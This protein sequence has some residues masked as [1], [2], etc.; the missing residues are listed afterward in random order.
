MG[1]LDFLFGRRIKLEAELRVVPSDPTESEKT[2]QQ[3]RIRLAEK[4]GGTPSDKDVHWS[5]YNKE[6][7]DHAKRQN[8][9]LYRNTRFSMAEQL[10]GENKLKAALDT[11]CEVSFLDAN[12][13]SNQNGFVSREF[14]AFRKDF[15]FQAP[16]VVSRI[17]T[18]AQELKFQREDLKSAYLAAAAK[19][20]SAVELPL[21]PEQA[22][23]QLEK[24]LGGYEEAAAESAAIDK[25]FTETKAKT[26]ELIPKE[27]IKESELHKL[28]S[29]AFSEDASE[30]SAY[31]IR[32]Y[33]EE[34]QRA[35]LVARKKEGRNWFVF[36]SSAA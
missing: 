24:D 11:F 12:G 16:G 22:W 20:S 15:A 17:T 14:P 33:T 1:L 32:Q 23:K 6:L 2:F 30:V 25:W 29:Q 35:G 34:F 4:L 36:K 13:P 21:T 10:K 19:L 27:G 8:W 31:R 28:V 18:I 26:L 5:L 3:E 7:I 9:G